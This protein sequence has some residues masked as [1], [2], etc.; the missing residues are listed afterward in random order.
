VSARSPSTDWRVVG[1]SAIVIAAA[2]PLAHAG[3]LS[4]K[5]RA[6]AEKS[7]HHATPPL[8]GVKPSPLVNI[9]NR[10]THEWL[11]IDA[12]HPQPDDFVLRCHF[13]NRATHMDPRLIANII[14]AAVH[15]RRDVVHIVSAFRDPKFNLYLRKKGHE[16]ARD[17]M[18][19]R[20]QAIDFYIPKVTTP[21]L[22]A[23][24]KARK[25]G[26][27]GVYRDSGFVHMDTGPRRVWSG[28]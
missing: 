24:V 18:H 22:Y 5:D 11:G 25:L 15:F 27:V 6:R 17:S 16:V 19:T 3:D 2:A 1:L 7:L 28:E 23:W 13:T 21:A 10:N 8:P 12:N 14:A 26:G 4:K 20:G 9:Y